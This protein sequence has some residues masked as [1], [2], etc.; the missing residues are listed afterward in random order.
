MRRCVSEGTF[1]SG[2]ERSVTADFFAIE[3]TLTRAGNESK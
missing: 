3:R 1:G 2:S